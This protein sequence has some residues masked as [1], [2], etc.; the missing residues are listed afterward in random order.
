MYKNRY[1]FVLDFH[2]VEVYPSSFETQIEGIE[3][4]V[5]FKGHF[6]HCARADAWFETTLAPDHELLVLN[7]SS[8]TLR[9]LSLVLNP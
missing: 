5:L 4:N 6:S 8:S 3:K 1:I 2:E 9:V 7:G